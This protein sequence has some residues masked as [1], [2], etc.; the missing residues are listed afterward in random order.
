MFSISQIQEAHSRVKAGSDFPKYIQDLIKLGV[1]KYDTYVA[2]GHGIYFGTDNYEIKSEAKYQMLIVADESDGEKFRQYL[3]IHQQG[4]TD[5]MTFCSHSAECG[6]EK[7]T[8]NMVE[9]TCIYFD[10]QGTQILAETIP[11]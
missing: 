10:K 11:G 5:Y 4:E 7:W 2:D 1:T 3:K 8:V 9:M 6:I